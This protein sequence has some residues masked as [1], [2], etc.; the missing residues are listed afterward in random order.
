MCL[1]LKVVET[2]I[3]VTTLFQTRM[4]NADY[5]LS[6]PSVS[7]VVSF[8]IELRKTFLLNHVTPTFFALHFTLFEYT[9]FRNRRG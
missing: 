4:I 5:T 1:K 8:Q 9:Y 2:K 7:E 3:T 6:Y